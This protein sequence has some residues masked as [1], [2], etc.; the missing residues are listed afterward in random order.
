MGFRTKNYDSDIILG[1][2]YRDTQTK[3]EGIAIA[4]CFF[5]HGCERVT[6]EL[7]NHEGEIR[8]YVFDAPRLMH[9]DTEKVARKTDTGGPSKGP[10]MGRRMPGR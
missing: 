8:E 1:E 3:I 7:L 10:D 4:T 6:L 9:V 5:Q 2:R